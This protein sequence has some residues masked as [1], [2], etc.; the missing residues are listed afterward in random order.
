[1]STLTMTECL[2]IFKTKIPCNPRVVGLKPTPKNFIPSR[3]CILTGQRH[4]KT[5]AVPLKYQDS[6]LGALGTPLSL[7]PNLST[8][9]PNV[10]TIV[11]H[12]STAVLGGVQP[13]WFL[14][15]R[16]RC[17]R[18]PLFESTTFI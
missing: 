12:L 18:V 15:S 7:V 10:S 13:L 17:I 6:T 1:M 8:M 4:A 11:L 14:G 2:R 3:I 16:H 9:V 5:G